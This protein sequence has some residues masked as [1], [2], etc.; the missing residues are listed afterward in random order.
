G[1]QRVRRHGDVQG[2]GPL[3]GP[4]EDHGADASDRRASRRDESRG[5]QE[6]GTP[7]SRLARRH[8]RQREPYGDVGRPG[9]LLQSP[10][11]VSPGGGEG[12]LHRLE[13]AGAFV[14]AAEGNGRMLVFPDPATLARAAADDFVRRASDA[15]A[16]RGRFTV[17]LS[18]GT[19]PRRLYEL[20]AGEPYRDRVPWAKTHLFWGD[21]RHVPPDDPQSN[22][23]MARE[24]ML[25]K[26]PIPE[27]N[28]H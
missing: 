3:E 11:P 16:A 27:T 13:Q 17:A 7:D 28:V 19:T 8:P 6:D 12:R 14:S 23:R 4:A 24:A 2:L 18:G 26:V 10:H 5:H 9:G 21:E 20:L 22:Y 15:I 1:A 25:S